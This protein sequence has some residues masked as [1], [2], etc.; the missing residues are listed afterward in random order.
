MRTVSILPLTLLTAGCWTPAPGQSDPTRYPWNPRNRVAVAPAPV[1]A[2]HPRVDARG[3]AKV[4][5]DPSWGALPPQGP[6]DTSYCVMEIERES[7]SGITTGANAGVVAC[8]VK[9]NAAPGT[10]PR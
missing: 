6:V 10:P 5:L 3:I 9:P 4:A 8:S 2:P 7:T 1:P